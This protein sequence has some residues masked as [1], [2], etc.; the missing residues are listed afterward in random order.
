MRPEQRIHFQLPAPFEPVHLIA[1]ELR[2]RPN[3]K[4]VIWPFYSLAHGRRGTRIA[5]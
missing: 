1:I 2:T 4:F 3:S 5:D